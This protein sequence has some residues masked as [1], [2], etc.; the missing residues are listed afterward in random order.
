MS[1]LV[2]YT[3]ADTLIWF[4]DFQIEIYSLLLTPFYGIVKIKLIMKLFGYR[5]FVY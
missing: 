1:L 2:K 5:I 3:M 4:V